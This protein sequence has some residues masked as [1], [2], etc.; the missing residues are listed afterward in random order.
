ME[1][2]GERSLS[3]A[4]GRQTGKAAS[5]RG[6]SN[7]KAL[8]ATLEVLGQQT[9]GGQEDVISLPAISSLSQTP[10]TAVSEVTLMW[11]S[12]NLEHMCC[13]W[14]RGT[15]G[16]RTVLCLPCGLGGTQV[17]RAQLACLF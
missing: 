17:T 3:A 12:H 16:T 10:S 9:A 5:P 8:S 15:T 6:L 14:D 13:K 11:H 4:A 1:R 7:T 2:D